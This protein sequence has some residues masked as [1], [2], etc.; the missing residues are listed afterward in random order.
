MLYL[1]F[2]LLE[3][4]VLASELPERRPLGWVMRWLNSYA[5]V[6]GRAILQM[7]REATGG[8]H[9]RAAATPR[10]S[11]HSAMDAAMAVVSLP[12]ALDMRPVSRPVRRPAPAARATVTNPRSEAVAL[13]RS[14][15]APALREAVRTRD[16]AR[17]VRAA[18]RRRFQFMAGILP[19]SGGRPGRHRATAVSG[20]F[21]RV[22]RRPAAAVP[23]RRGRS[24]TPPVSV[25]SDRVPALRQPVRAR[26]EV[27]LSLGLC[28]RLGKL[29]SGTAAAVR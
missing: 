12:M 4:G 5:T 16:S 2:R 26:P 22:S 27:C 6:G 24:G 20:R 9:R 13:T 1:C 18:E 25:A 7:A 14:G 19:L 3:R 8:R 21:R 29:V 10:R 11:P 28:R 15:R 17:P 23:A